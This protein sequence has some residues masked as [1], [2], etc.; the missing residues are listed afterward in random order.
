MACQLESGARPTERRGLQ[1]MT[2]APVADPDEPDDKTLAPFRE[3]IVRGVSGPLA[4]PPFCKESVALGGPKA[5]FERHKGASGALWLCAA[6]SCTTKRPSLRAPAQNAPKNGRHLF[7]APSSNLI[8]DQ[9]VQP[10][11]IEHFVASWALWPPTTSR[12][13]SSA[14]IRRVS[15]ERMSFLGVAFFCM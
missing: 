13:L 4:P 14:S 9:I 3:G 5:A 11:Q 7:P 2:S 6:S 10:G 15:L 1:R 8:R 12:S